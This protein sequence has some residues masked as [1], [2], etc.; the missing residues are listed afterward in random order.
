MAISRR[1]PFPW[2]N[3]QGEALIGE[4]RVVGQRPGS[5]TPFTPQRGGSPG[6]TT[7][8]STRIGEGGF[9]GGVSPRRGG[10]TYISPLGRPATAYTGGTTMPGQLRLSPQTGSTGT[11]TGTVTWEPSAKPEPEFQ[12]SEA[13]VQRRAAPEIRAGR[14]ALQDALRAAQS[15]ATGP[16]RRAGIAAALREWSQN[17]GPALRRARAAET[18]KQMGIWGP[19][20]Q[21]WMRAGTQR[22]TG[23]TAGQQYGPPRIQP[24]V[25]SPGGPYRYYAKGGHIS[26][27]GPYVVGEEGPE[28]FVPEQSGTIIPNPKTQERMG[29]TRFNFRDFLP[30]QYGGRVQ[31]GVFSPPTTGLRGTGLLTSPTAAPPTRIS[32]GIAPPT[33]TTDITSPEGGPTVIPQ[34]TPVLG[35]PPQRTPGVADYYQSLLKQRRR[36][37]PMRTLI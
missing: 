9:A 37:T 14:R 4:T 30:R 28:V 12:I 36:Q 15:A 19:R 35:P 1:A 32:P 24:G 7:L 21:A 27:R 8:F 13:E 26:A 11:T 5:Q 20:F 2:V 23:T 29:G 10:S 16:T 17:I 33:E 22:T 25:Y 31:K 18:Q 34:P 6:M 3:P